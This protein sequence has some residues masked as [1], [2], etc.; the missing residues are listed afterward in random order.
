MKKITNEE[1]RRI[2]DKYEKK[3]KERVPMD[4]LK[5]EVKEDEKFS[6]QYLKFK[7]ELLRGKVTFYEKA[8]NS[9]EKLIKVSQKEE[10]K[11]ELKKSIETCH[12][13]TTPEG[14]AS[15]AVITGMSVA[16]LGFLILL[17]SFLIGFILDGI[18]GAL[19]SIL[20]F[21][22]LMLIISG[23]LLIKPLTLYPKKLANQWRLKSSNQMVMCILYIVMYMKHTS[24]LE[25]AI[26]FASE[27]VGDP[28]SLDL[29]KVFWDV[30][31]EKFSKIQDS[32]DHYLEIWR[33]Y[34]LEFIES[35]HL[36]ES[37]LYEPDEKRRVDLL[38]KALGVMLEGTYEN[39]LHY[40]QEIKGPITMLHMLGIILPILGLII[41]PLLG[42][43]LGIKWYYLGFVYNI[44]LPL[45]VFYIGSNI[46]DKRPTGYGPSTQTKEATEL[47]E[48]KTNLKTV[49][50]LIGGIL[51][52]LGL[53]PILLH[54]LSIPEI[55]L[56]FFGDFPGYKEA[57]IDTGTKLVGPFSNLAAFF[58]LLIPLGIAL[59]FAIYYSVLSR[60]KIGI[61]KSAVE[62]E[63][64]FAGSLFQ[65]GNR[66]G[67]GIPVEAA[68]E[69]VARNMKGTKTGEFFSLININI[70]RLGMDVK[71][72]IFNR[73]KGAMRLFP[74]VLIESSMK[75]L[76]ETA[77]KGPQI[78]SN[79][80]ISISNYV[81][82]IHEVAERMKD[83]LADI[84]SSMKS[85]IKFLT[86][87]IAGIVVAIGTMITIIV[88]ILSEKIGEVSLE[89]AGAEAGNLALTIPS[90]FPPEK[91]IPPYFFQ[92]VVG[93]YVVEI[94]F[95]LTVLSNGIEN[96]IDR[97]QEADSLG[98]NLYKSTVLYVIISLIF[99]LVFGLLA[100]KI[101]GVTI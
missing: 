54:M 100:T 91:I 98:K 5:E 16:G 90:L 6:S 55:E 59:G 99:M 48:E 42:T 94:V 23:L 87:V 62:L 81:S 95:I 17:L 32:L 77:R 9:C 22:P 97:L 30:E 93:I 20:F 73:E 7:E 101:S 41:L 83:L 49:P 67:D 86:P 50:L 38:E 19:Q 34:N 45:V 37:S 36:I 68:F 92:I 66:V 39:M 96:G 51:V 29:K 46:L 71:G 80:L 24:N 14:A 21:I 72:A 63:K 40:A 8:C 4:L 58:S 70:R 3:L 2:L 56:P 88:N 82:K 31:T 75:V 53:V 69:N 52:F 84:L 28:L 13:Q 65:L 57:Q 85:Q 47:T 10:Q 79:S 44:F 18:T 60:G 61:R 25:H 64:E 43:F 33:G 76:V 11:A 15:F 27:H 78:V 74:S 1:V 26:R 89:G 35:M 12:L